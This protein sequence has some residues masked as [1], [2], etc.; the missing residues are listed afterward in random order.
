MEPASDTDDEFD[1]QVEDMTLPPVPVDPKDFEDDE[2]SSTTTFDEQNIPIWSST[3]P[4]ET[5][6]DQPTTM[7]INMWEQEKDSSMTTSPEISDGLKPMLKDEDSVSYSAVYAIAIL[8]IFNLAM[9]GCCFF[10]CRVRR[11]RIRRKKESMKQT[12]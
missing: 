10:A 7:P 3:I 8:V 6:E 1:S 11:D 4:I 2:T 9:I 12:N 5:E